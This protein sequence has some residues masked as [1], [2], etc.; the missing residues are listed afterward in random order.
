MHARLTILMCFL[1]WTPIRAQVPVVRMTLH[2]RD[3]RLEDVFDK[4]EKKTGY[5]FVYDVANLRLSERVTFSLDDAPLSLLLASC[6]QNQ[7]LTYTLFDMTV[8]VKLKEG[9]HPPIRPA[10]TTLNLSGRVVNDKKE[11]VPGASIGVKGMG[12][13][14]FAG[15]DGG[16]SLS[17]LKPGD[18]LLVSCVGYAP[19]EVP[20]HEGGP[21]DIPLKMFAGTLDETVIIA[22][23][24]TTRRLNTGSVSKVTHSDIDLQPVA[25]PMAALE[26]RVPGLLITQSNGNPGSYFKVQIRGQNSILQGS[27]PLF[28]VDGVPFAA[29]NNP[30]GQMASAAGPNAG[31]GSIL[32][33]GLSP[34]ILLNPS[35]IESI[36]ILKDA[37]ATAIYGSRGANGVVLITTRKAP[38]GK[39][40]VQ[41][42][43]Y[44]G[45]GEVTRTMP[46]MTSRPYL[47]M[48]REGF[49][50]DGVT[51]T[52]ANAPDLLLWDTTRYTN[53]P[54]LLIGG[55]GATTDANVSLSTG[56]D[57]TQF[58]MSG[59]YHRQ[60][61]VFSN[62]LADERTGVYASLNQR[63]ADKRF[64]LDF[65]LDVAHD[66]NTSIA[67]DLTSSINLPPDY[68]SLTTPSGTLNWQDKGVSFMVNPLAY[69]QDR[70]NATTSGFLSHLQLSYRVVRG[71][72]LKASMGYN[73]IQVDETGVVPISAQNPASSPTG[74]AEFGTKYL[75][76][77][78]VEPQME[79]TTR[80]WTGKLV[81]LAGSTLQSLT[82]SASITSGYGY[83][84]DALLGS[85]NGA[86]GL[87]SVNS[88][89]LY[90]YEAR[91]FGRL[92]YDLKDRYL[93][94]LSF[95]DDGSSRFGPG[96]QYARF[97]AAG[98][99]W[100][101]SH[102][103]AIREGLRFLS[104]GKLRAS[105]GITGNDQI[106]DYQYLD[107]W[108]STPYPYLGTSSLFPNRLYNPQYGW[109]INRKLAV[110]L[111][112]GFIHDRILLTAE[113]YQDRG[114]NQ[115]IKYG[116]PLQTGFSGITENFPALVQNT[117]LEWDLSTKNVVTR[118]FTWTTTFNLT[119]PRNELLSFPGIATSSYANL[120]IG[121]PLSIVG[122]YVYTGVN[123]S[124][125]VYTFKDLNKDGQIT[126]PQD[127]DKNLGYLSPSLFGGLGNNVTFRHWQLDVFASFR[128]QTG[129]N[130]FYFYYNN[131]NIP[132]TLYNQPVS[133]GAHWRAPE[134][135]GPLQRY[136]AGYDAATYLAGYDLANS[137]AAFSSASFI[138]IS[139][140]SLA[141]TLSGDALKKWGL[142]EGQLYLRAQ[143]LFT[144]THYNGSDPETQNTNVLPPLR[145]VVAGVR[146]EL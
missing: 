26:G 8:V 74:F 71:L 122:G 36:E 125:G 77:W 107:I 17:G 68:P 90:R 100:I 31:A 3:A 144:I 129:P 27:D 108:S 40:S 65:M 54:H 15:E 104:F 57:L 79:Y 117:G 141:Y 140:I 56:N 106:G 91:Y 96:K 116:L 16:F 127:Y 139:T 146:L 6:F 145:V 28:V 9:Y 24:T 97:G 11:P 95:R 143:N 98:A 47:E 103:K 51:P 73:A 45:A 137:S 121:Q 38:P 94:N 22:Y 10:A 39:T 63:S 136:T 83:T 133:A 80:V 118:S 43:F 4:I 132:G 142:K 86:A 53:F 25:D 112:L 14:T 131:G 81:V 30:L 44:S 1:I 58:Y 92:N 85:T 87:S 35:D 67:Q 33:G 128:R 60:A 12:K 62:H 126:Y 5:F 105:Y 2:V 52:A 111:E 55:R 37:D 49:S 19:T 42:S 113:A 109:E 32:T 21:L 20:V 138:R 78:I 135:Q 123:P 34:F 7:P 66:D 18:T 99:A 64:A 13:G 75:R 124:T 50:N 48:R 115:L 102:T 119:I 70:Y 41:A 89:S 69:L 114:G 61:S 88:S 101:F 72:T 93:L 84:D 130:Y 120:Q 46:L 110:A 134:R 29:N 76:N 59:N 23:G 82:N